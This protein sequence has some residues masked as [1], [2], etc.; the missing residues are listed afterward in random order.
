[1][2]RRAFLAVGGIAFGAGCSGL[3]GDSKREKSP[4]PKECAVDPSVTPGT[5]EWPSETGGQQN[6][7]SVPTAEVPAPPLALDWT[8]TMDGYGGVPC[9]VV[10]GATVYTTNFEDELHA[11][12][13]TTGAKR[14]RVNRSMNAAPAVSGKRVFI[15]GDD[16]VTALDTTSGDKRW[17][18]ES[19]AGRGRYSTGV[20]VAE[21]TVFVSGHMSLAAF[22]AST[23]EERWTFI[24]GLEI[25]SLPAVSDGTV[26]VGS[27]DTYLYALDAATGDRR[28]RYKTDGRVS[29]DPVVT[30]DLVYVGSEEGTLY[31]LDA[32]SGNERWRKEVGDIGHL[33]V[34]GGHVYVGFGSQYG[35]TMLA[36]TAEN[37]VEC[38]SS[39]AYEAGYASSIAA[40]SDYL[41]LPVGSL[42]ESY[43]ETFGALDPKTGE[44]VWRFSNSNVRFTSGPAVTDGAVYAGGMGTEGLTVARFVPKD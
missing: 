34:D 14:W 30:R 37:G 1:M 31:A 6:T 2:R 36:F 9:P 42:S 29:C 3:V 11:V 38:W 41:Y 19:A 22:D 44:T 18:T 33:A 20:Q 26:Y 24:T 12:N 25:E 15:A 10:V 43:S 16:A 28:W 35:P 27:D 7:G 32:R 17:S 5:A 13:V 8:Y 4:P 39:D 40:S 23:G 21:G